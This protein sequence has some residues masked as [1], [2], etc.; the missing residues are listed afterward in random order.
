[1]NDE[2]AVVTAVG[3]E[4]GDDHGYM[5]HALFGSLAGDA[6]LTELIAMAVGGRRLSP[7]EVRVLDDVAGVMAVADPRVWPLKI[8]RLVASEGGFMIGLCAGQ[9]CLE[10][11][12]VGPWSCGA[13]ARLLIQLDEWIGSRMEDAQL[14]R[15]AVRRALE[16]GPLVGFGVPIRPADERVEALGRILTHRGRAGLHYWRLLGAVARA[17]RGLKGIAP[18]IGAGV[19]AC[20]LDLELSPRQI[21]PLATALIID[22]F[23]ANAFEGAQQRAALLQCLPVAAVRYT[24][25]APRRS[26]RAR[27]R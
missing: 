27:S 10:G 11:A 22:T 14:V 9:L 1:M 17:V 3:A 13:A 4:F 21:G 16:R 8:A 7:E 25:P 24:G 12:R 26:P 15:A 20:M 23:V 6:T 18:N 19:G 2:P 5:G